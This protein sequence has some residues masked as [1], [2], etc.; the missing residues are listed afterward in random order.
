MPRPRKPDGA[1]TVSVTRS[2]GRSRS[3]PVTMTDG[4]RVLASDL[5]PGATYEFDPET[6]AIRRSQQP[7]R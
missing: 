4:S 5:Q 6:G 1:V 2:E 7:V 3:L